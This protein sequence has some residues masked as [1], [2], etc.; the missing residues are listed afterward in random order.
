MEAKPE[1]CMNGV[2]TL[3]AM[4]GDRAVNKKKRWTKTGKSARKTQEQAEAERRLQMEKTEAKLTDLDTL[5]SAKQKEVRLKGME[6][7]DNEEDD[8]DFGDE[9]ALT[10]QEAAEKAHRKKSLRFYTSQIA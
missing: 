9:E 7:K 3:I 10:A 2:S 4:N 1:P 6:R 5:I 8:S